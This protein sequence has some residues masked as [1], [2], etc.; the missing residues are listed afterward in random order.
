MSHIKNI[1]EILGIQ[2]GSRDESKH[3]NVG[4][5]NGLST[6]TDSQLFFGSQFWLDNSQGASQDMSL[7]PRT[8]QQSSQEGSG[9]KFSSSYQN[10]PL[11]FE[12]FKDK[13][14]AFGLLDK[15]EED[16]K[17]AKEKIDWDHLT[18]EFH[19]FRETLCNIQQVVAGTEKNTAACQ[20]IL[21][22]YIKEFSST[23]QN[24]LNSLQSSI[25]QKFETLQDKVNSQNKATAEL[26]RWL[27]K[28]GESTAE[29]GSNLQIL[30]KSLQGLREEQGREGNLLQEALNL[31]STLV[32][33]HSAK[34]SPKGGVDSAIQTSP[35]LEQQISNCLQDNMLEDTQRSCVTNNSH[36]SQVEVLPQDPSPIIG[37]RKYS[38]KSR[39][40]GKK[41]PLV[42]SK[43]SKP[44]FTDE[45][46]Q[47][48][49][50][51]NKEQNVSLPPCE[52]NEMNTVNNQDRC[53][54]KPL[55]RKTGSKAGG[56]V[57]NPLSCWSQDS[58]G[59]ECLAGIKPCLEKLS[60]E[61]KIATPVKA[62]GLWQLFDMGSEINF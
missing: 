1:K 14:K 33:E 28:S 21:E 19:L 45:N 57:I 53:C 54:L 18:K 7:S 25:S 47:P 4:A 58:S 59:S 43:R 8:S 16:K 17:K 60:P 32:S 24:N 11:L 55:N 31:L 62:G 6:F 38:L 5:T 35:G 10:K 26:E 13:N 3:R 61:S 42:L 12:D 52:H 34:P 36:H 49:I 48:L 22:Q 30:K 23:L 29:L 46:R 39:K 56:C 20:T 44:A 41:R 15:F 9:P 50:N 2:T 37:K 40:R 27:L 51:F